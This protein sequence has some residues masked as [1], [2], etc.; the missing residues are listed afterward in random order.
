MHLRY[1][2]EV[3]SVQEILLFEKNNLKDKGTGILDSL[4]VPLYPKTIVK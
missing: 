4:S 2:V 3:H 1:L